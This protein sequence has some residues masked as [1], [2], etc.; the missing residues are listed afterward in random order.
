MM[1]NEIDVVSALVA[2]INRRSPPDISDRHRPL[3]HPSTVKSGP[4]S[5]MVKQMTRYDQRKFTLR[6]ARGCII[7]PVS[8]R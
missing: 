1:S 5:R 2:A 4:I 7:S 3:G 8:D 6:Q